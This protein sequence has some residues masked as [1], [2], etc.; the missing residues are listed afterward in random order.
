MPQFTSFAAA[1][2]LFAAVAPVAQVNA[3]PWGVARDAALANNAAGA[4]YVSANSYLELADKLQ[5]H[6][7]SRY[8]S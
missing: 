2:G 1:V 7:A 6:G 4:V 5:S 3:A 8:S